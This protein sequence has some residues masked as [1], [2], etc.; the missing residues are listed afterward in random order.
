[1]AKLIHHAKAISIG[2]LGGWAV[3]VNGVTIIPKVCVV[4][5]SSGSSSIALSVVISAINPA[6][7]VVVN[8]VMVAGAAAMIGT[9]IWQSVNSKKKN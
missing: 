5:M 7:L 8:N 6:G 1:M 2:G 3:W 9:S 4:V